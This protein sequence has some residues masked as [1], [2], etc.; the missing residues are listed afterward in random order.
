MRSSATSTAAPAPARQT[1]RDW[2]NGPPASS[3]P[4]TTGAD[5]HRYFGRVRRPRRDTGSVDTTVVAVHLNAAHVFSKTPQ[6]EL[7]LVAGMGVMGDAHFGPT[8]RHRSRVAADPTQPNLRQVHLLSAEVLDEFRTAGYDV[9]SGD[10]GE[11]ITTARLD[12]H[13][14]PTGALLRIG[15]C[16]LALTGLRNPCRQIEEFRS[17]LLGQVLRRD[18]H[19]GTERRAGVMA[20]VVEGGRIRAGDSIAVQVPPA[21]HTPLVRV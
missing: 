19:G 9:K 18:E 20:V 1:G 5:Q 4:T 10:L 16:L 8:V 15:P 17:G 13:A 6:V 2:R 7:E 12:L 11:N 3:A 21:P 14:L